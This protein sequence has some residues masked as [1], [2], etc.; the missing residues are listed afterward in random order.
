MATKEKGLEEK[1]GQSIKNMHRDVSLTRFSNFISSKQ[2]EPKIITDPKKE[3]NP[4]WM[5]LILAD[6]ESLKITLRIF[7]SEQDIHPLVA[8]S[9]RKDMS[10]VSSELIDDF[11]KEY[12]NLTQGG[13]KA[14]LEPFG[15][16]TNIS[17]P[18]LTK[19]LEN[20]V[21]STQGPNVFE[22]EWYIAWFENNCIKCKASI[23]VLN[24]ET[25]KTLENAIATPK[26]TGGIEML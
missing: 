4:E 20:V 22:D 26:K 23:E 16:N 9:L 19:G 13:V 15:V 10:S 2:E 3:F 12:A 25:V 21:F 17:L 6:G 8:S 5:V 14:E 18:L 7:F 1:I 11:M 24:W